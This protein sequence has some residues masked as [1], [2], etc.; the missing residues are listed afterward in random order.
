MPRRFD[1][2]ILDLDGTLV[3]SEDILVGLVNSTL[4]AA[5]WAPAPPRA[6]AALIG[7]PLEEVFRNVAPDL[8]TDGIAAL[9]SEYRACAD[10]AE[11]VAQFRLYAEVD[12]TLTELRAHSVR[13]A[14]ATS[15]GR[16]TTLD[17]LTHC[18]IAHHVDQVI[19]GDCVERGKPHP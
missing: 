9:C 3:D 7:L 2:V 5:G 19:G 4:T 6:V 15:K 17:I 12:A 1:L 16:A 13:M 8:A 18:A 10:A 11:F 14:V